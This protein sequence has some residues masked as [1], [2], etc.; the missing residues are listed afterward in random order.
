M[1]AWMLLLR[2]WHLILVAVTAWTGFVGVK[3]YRKGAE[4]GDAKLAA[5]D[6]K[7]DANVRK[8]EQAR[9]RVRPTVQPAAD[10]VR[11]PNCRR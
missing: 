5:I 8:A 11:D 7:A 4:A 9:S 10:C 6:K 2:P 1:T 3:A